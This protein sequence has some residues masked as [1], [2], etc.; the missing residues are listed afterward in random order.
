MARKSAPEVR[1]V[2]LESNKRVEQMIPGRKYRMVIWTEDT[3]EGDTA[4]FRFVDLEGITPTD[5]TLTAEVATSS[6]K[7]APKRYAFFVKEILPTKVDSGYLVVTYNG[8]EL[9]RVEVDVVEEEEETEHPVGAWLKANWMFLLGALILLGLIGW[10]WSSCGDDGASPTPTTYYRDADGDTY[11]NLAVTKVATKQPA[12]YVA[13]NSDCNDANP[14]INPAAAEIEDGLD[15]DCNGK[16]DDT[17]A[18]T[19]KPKPAA[20][21][22]YTLVPAHDPGESTSTW[23]EPK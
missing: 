19:P 3:K 17:V 4:A 1:F 15:N 16:A 22:G 9:P 18:P 23:V 8:D 20:D 10:D 2:D 7:K 6:I 21:L 13:N 5:G 11:G 14:A 12:G